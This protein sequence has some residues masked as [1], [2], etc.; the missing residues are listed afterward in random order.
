MKDGEGEAMERRGC[1]H[2]LDTQ[3]AQDAQGTHAGNTHAQ[4]SRTQERSALA[5]VTQRR[6]TQQVSNHI[7]MYMILY[8]LPHH[9]TCTTHNHIHHQNATTH[10]YIT[11][12]N[13]GTS[14]YQHS[15]HIYSTIH[16]TSS[17]YTSTDESI[18]TT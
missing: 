7:Y 8:S 3:D 12:H 15:I 2:I 1:S 4:R 13:V 6:P 11:N 18:H 10:S 5:Q 17:C 14:M 9:H 16:L